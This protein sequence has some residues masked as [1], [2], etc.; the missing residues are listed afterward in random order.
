MD[1][2]HPRTAVHCRRTGVGGGRLGNQPP[3]LAHQE[4]AQ[5][6]SEQGCRHDH[7]EANADQRL[8]CCAP[9]CGERRHRRQQGDMPCARR[10]RLDS[11]RE[12]EVRR[13][14][15]FQTRARIVH[16]GRER[17][18]TDAGS[19]G[20]CERAAG[21]VVNDDEG[22][23]PKA[24]SRQD[25]QQ[26]CRID[27]RCDHGRLR[28]AIGHR[29]DQSRHRPVHIRTREDIGEERASGRRDLS[30]Q[31]GA[32]D[33]ARRDSGCRCRI[34][35]ELARSA[36]EDQGHASRGGD[37]PQIS[38]EAV[39]VPRRQQRRSGKCLG[40]DS[41]PREVDGD[42]GSGVSREALEFDTLCTKLE[43]RGPPRNADT[44]RRQR[45]NRG[46]NECDKIGLEPRERSRATP[47]LKVVFRNSRTER[48]LSRQ[49]NRDAILVTGLLRLAA[50]VPC[51]RVRRHDN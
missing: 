17:R 6:Q 50:L 43:S 15:P 37:G 25:S 19:G 1:L 10:D 33:G 5:Q 35:N 45:Q 49:C 42:R 3:C 13:R 9:G 26:F 14:S 51:G 22:T 24:R 48:W 30:H 41:R 31:I 36:A 18:D 28:T 39:D 32:R 4:P 2:V 40:K 27:A 46:Q 47:W 29:H 12:S 23:A 8:E 11:R 34:D 16:V 38:L 44:E 20:A 21:T 7:D